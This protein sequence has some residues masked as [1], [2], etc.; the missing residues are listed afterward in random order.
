MYQNDKE[1]WTWFEPN[2]EVAAR[3]LREQYDDWVK[4]ERVQSP[5]G[6]RA[7]KMIHENYTWGHTAT[8]INAILEKVIPN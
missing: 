8:K 6:R 7:S 1:N 5:L 2:F 3:K 4:R